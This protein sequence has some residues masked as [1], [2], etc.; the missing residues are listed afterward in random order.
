MIK[1][2]KDLSKNEIRAG[3]LTAGQ[4]A[5]DSVHD[6]KTDKYEMSETN[7]T[8]IRIPEEQSKYF[9]EGLNK[10]DRRASNHHKALHS[11]TFTACCL[12]CAFSTAYA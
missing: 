3:G 5:Q 8:G 9:G 12:L 6:E 7:K 2:R 1:I 4:F 11:I 10:V